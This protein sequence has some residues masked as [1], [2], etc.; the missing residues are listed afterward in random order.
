M[1]RGSAAAARGSVSR[2]G[3][4]GPESLLSGGVPNLQLDAA[5]FPLGVLYLQLLHLKVYADGADEVVREM[6]VREA[7]EQAGLAHA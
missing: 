2:T 4:D 5:A 7:H 6:S 1:Q 3:G